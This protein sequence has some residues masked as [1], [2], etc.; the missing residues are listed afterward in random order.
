ME[1]S[2]FGEHRASFVLLGKLPA[3]LGSDRQPDSTALFSRPFLKVSWDRRTQP[4]SVKGVLSMGE[5]RMLPGT[6]F[7]SKGSLVILDPDG[8]TVDSGSF[9]MQPSDT[10]GYFLCGAPRRLRP[11]VAYTARVGMCL[12]PLAESL[13]DASSTVLKEE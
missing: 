13:E 9:R 2:L 3:A 7:S 12:S 5:F 6:G 1:T 10:T 8:K 11:M 4:A